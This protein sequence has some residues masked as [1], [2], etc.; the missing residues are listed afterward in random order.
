MSTDENMRSATSEPHVL[1]LSEP[2]DLNR[3]SDWDIDFRQIEPGLMKTRIVTNHGPDMALL[4]IQMDRAVHQAGCSPQGMLTFGITSAEAV[5]WHLN[6]RYRPNFIDFGT[7][8]EYE[9]VTNGKFS[10]LVYS[11]SERYAHAVNG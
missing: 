6:D 10:G 7:G 8:A 11:I 5:R 4:N 3:F 1:D 9:S 2:N